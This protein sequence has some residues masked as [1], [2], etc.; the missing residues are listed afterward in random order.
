MDKP[1]VYG[2]ILLHPMLN[3]EVMFVSRT[4]DPYWFMAMVVRNGEARLHSL[5]HVKIGTVSRYGSLPNWTRA[6]E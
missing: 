2:T 1:I 5:D 6:D 3:I 4:P